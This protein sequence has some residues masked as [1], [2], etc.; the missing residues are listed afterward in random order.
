MKEHMHK[1]SLA[2]LLAFSV[3]ACTKEPHTAATRATDIPAPVVADKPATAHTEQNVVDASSVE[4]DGICQGLDTDVTMG[5]YEC[6]GRKFIL[7]DKL[8]NEQYQQRMTM[9]H[10]E[11]QT[12]LRVSQRA[13][14]KDKDRACEQAGKE[15]EGGSLE[16]VVAL[17]CELRMTQ[18]RTTYL[19]NYR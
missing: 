2:I 6:D 9:L 15:Y 4:P 19:A 12:A 11:R 10:P 8:L 5:R 16:R 17:Q 7:A 3:V 18:E 13:W 14:L 1:A